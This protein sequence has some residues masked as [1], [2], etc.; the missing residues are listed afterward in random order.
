[1]ELFAHAT[2][3]A[4][5]IITS[6]RANFLVSSYVCTSQIAKIDQIC[7][8]LLPN[9]IKFGRAKAIFAIDLL[10]SVALLALF[11]DFA[12]YQSLRL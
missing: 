3:L 12:L 8:N 2:F 11:L 4:A 9:L 6:G 1:L 7:S 10:K 5:P